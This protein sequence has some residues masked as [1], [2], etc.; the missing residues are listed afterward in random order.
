MKRT[1]LLVLF[2]AVALAGCAFIKEG[3]PDLAHPRVVVAPVMVGPK[4]YLTVGQEP[5]IVVRGGG[6][7]AVTWTLPGDGLRFERGRGVEIVGRIKNPPKYPGQPPSKIEKP[8]DSQVRLFTC[9]TKED[10]LEVACTIPPQVS[11]GVYA[12]TINARNAAGPVVLDP[13]MWLD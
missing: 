13:T 2:C 7:A 8:D 3:A 4:V 1:P 9:V 11:S 10:L 5:V 6:S 12:Y